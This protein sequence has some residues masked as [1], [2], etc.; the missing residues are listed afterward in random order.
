M[1]QTSGPVRRRPAAR[2][3]FGFPL[4]IHYFVSRLARH[5]QKRIKSIPKESMKTLVN[6]DWP[7]NVRELENFIERCL[8]LTQGDHLQVPRSKLK[9][10]AVRTA[11]AGVH[12]KK[13]SGKQL[14]MR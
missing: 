11:G 4:L 10:S 3:S 7:G 1:I 6:A 8:I 14:A 2:M 9:R 12:S 13:P 5:M